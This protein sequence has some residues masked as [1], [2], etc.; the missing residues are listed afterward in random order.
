VIS[1]HEAITRLRAAR[2]VHDPDIQQ[3]F[4]VLDGLSDR[5]RAVG[6]IVRDTILGRP[7]M[8]SD[9]DLATEL[10]PDEVMARAG[11]AG[12]SCYPTGIAHGT[13]TVRHGQ[14]TAEVT[15]L[16]EDIKTDGRH[17]VVRFGS[18]W[19]A[20]ARRRDFTINAL[21]ASMNGGFFD[22]L[23][24]MDDLLNQRVRFIGDPDQ[25][26]AEDRLRVLRFFRFTASH[27]KEVCDPEGLAACQRAANGLGALSAERVGAEMMKMLS[28][29][30]VAATLAVMS[31]AGIVDFDVEVLEKLARYEDLTAAPVALARL[32]ILISSGGTE[33]LQNAW[34]LSKFTLNEAREICRAASLLAE[35]DLNQAAYRYARL[36]SVALPVAAGLGGW[37]PP[38]AKEISE[39]FYAIKVPGFPINGDDLVAAGFSRGPELGQALRSIERDWVNS[40]FKLDR[41]ALVERLQIYLA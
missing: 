19:R 10:P 26:I 30:R 16:R 40:G 38:H 1:R 11:A 23:D 35:G 7:D 3:M 17:A 33:N 36:G 15:T 18:N 28:V 32:A 24:G 8:H 4:K 21:Y 12:M 20:D 13:V 27:G 41:D 2:W 31:K 9:I 25:R 37:T 22:P 29:Q 5:T 39:A 14:T 6:G 34:R